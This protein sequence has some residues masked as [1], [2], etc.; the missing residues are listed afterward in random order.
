MI[1]KE[2]IELIDRDDSFPE[3]TTDSRGRL[4]IYCPVNCDAHLLICFMCEE[5]TWIRVPISSPILI[6]FYDCK[7]KNLY[8]EANTDIQVWLEYEK[9]LFDRYPEHLINNIPNSDI[10]SQE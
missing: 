3:I 9:Y 1:L 7:I 8:P 5:E 6:P 4:D 10:N 2:L